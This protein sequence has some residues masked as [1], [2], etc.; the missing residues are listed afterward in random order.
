[1]MIAL[2]T[3]F[4]VCTFNLQAM[5]PLPATVTTCAQMIYD[6]VP[7]PVELRA[8][9]VAYSAQE[10]WVEG[11]GI[12]GKKPWVFKN[13]CRCLAY[14]SPEEIVIGND[15]GSL[16][17]CDVYKEL[18]RSRIKA[19]I[20]DDYY[21][22]YY[23]LTAKP[24]GIC[25]VSAVIYDPAMKAIISG[26][27]DGLIK[28]W[29]S[30][31]CI[32]TRPFFYYYPNNSSG[33]ASLGNNTIVSTSR[34]SYNLYVW[35]YKAQCGERIFYD[36]PRLYGGTRSLSA[37]DTTQCVSVI[38]DN[39]VILWDVTV[40]RNVWSYRYPDVCTAALFCDDSTYAFTGGEDILLR[41]VR[42]G[43]TGGQV[44]F[45]EHA[46]IVK[47]LARLGNDILSASVDGTA[48]IWDLRIAK[49]CKNT[50][51]LGSEKRVLALAGSPAGT[52]FVVSF[53]EPFNVKIFKFLVL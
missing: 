30:H 29:K 9:I 23:G 18:C 52:S 49:V 26:G 22:G 42:S 39:I 27:K 43:E 14:I 5:A 24:I 10:Q 45:K 19:H 34:D 6:N 50:I 51:K 46:G 20:N 38:T 25:G 11:A 4:F 31:D 13:A 17:I 44:R 35:N 2:V 15:A 7:L 21:D 32:N 37:R 53:G 8:I 48:K 1:M 41:D 33:L 28:I 3:L 47:K 40:Q 16:E 12:R 36:K